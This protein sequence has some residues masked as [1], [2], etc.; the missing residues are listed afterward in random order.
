VK[1]NYQIIF[2]VEHKTPD[3]ECEMATECTLFEASSDQSI[4]VYNNMD[5]K[6]SILHGRHVFNMNLEIPAD[7]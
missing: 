4:S 1:Y 3:G 5:I 7:E 6:K 2:R